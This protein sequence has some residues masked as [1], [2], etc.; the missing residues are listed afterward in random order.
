MAAIVYDEKRH[1]TLTRYHQAV[2]RAGFLAEEEKINWF[3]LGSSLS[4]SELEGAE[5]AIINEDL[6]RLG[7]RNQLQKIKTM[8]VGTVSSEQ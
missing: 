2:K 8:Q 4:T 1:R 6:R 3:V 7:V 5:R